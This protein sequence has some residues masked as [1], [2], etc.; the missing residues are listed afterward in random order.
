MEQKNTALFHNRTALESYFIYLQTKSLQRYALFSAH[1]IKSE[2]ITLHVKNNSVQ[3]FSVYSPGL[4]K[5]PLESILSTYALSPN[6]EP[7]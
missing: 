2:E 7:A 6:T 5:E 3:G 4:L 1:Q